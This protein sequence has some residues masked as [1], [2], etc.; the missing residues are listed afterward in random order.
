MNGGSELNQDRRTSGY[1][2][3]A[4][5]GAAALLPRER[6]RPGRAPPS[7][8]RQV[9]RGRGQSGTCVQPDLC[10]RHPGVQGARLG[11]AAL[12]GRGHF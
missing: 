9:G 4:L 8:Q 6:C 7:A 11:G 5:W 3:E 1:P 12:Q 2:A 10:Q